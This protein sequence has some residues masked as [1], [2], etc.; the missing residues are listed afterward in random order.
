MF[1]RF[2][3]AV[4]T[5][6]DDLARPAK[7]ALFTDVPEQL[8][9]LGPG[10]GTNFAYFPRGTKVIAFE[11]NVAFHDPL[12]RAA[13]EHGIELDLHATELSDA[14]LPAGTQDLVVS[15]FVL[16]SV[17][18]LEATLEEIHRILRPGGSLSFIEHVAAPPGSGRVAYQRLVRRPWRVIGD[19][20][21]TCAPTMRAIE[22]SRLSVLDPTLEPLGSTLDPTNLTYWGRAVKR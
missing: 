6:V 9:E 4:D 7:R 3:A 20:C 10:R 17:P 1:A 12:R 5:S 21:D 18:H 14:G 2:W 15:T 19:G 16:C 22:G 13:D 11:A 8:V